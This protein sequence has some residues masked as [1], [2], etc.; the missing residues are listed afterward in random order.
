MR[1][2]HEQGVYCCQSQ[3]M[4][5]GGPTRTVSAAPR[6]PA[7]A[8][9]TTAPLTTDTPATARKAAGTLYDGSGTTVGSTG[10]VAAARAFLLNAPNCTS[11][12]T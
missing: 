7:M 1:Q 3:I 11:Q 2:L 6:M 4:G 12:Q 9:G 10:C 5:G 8:A